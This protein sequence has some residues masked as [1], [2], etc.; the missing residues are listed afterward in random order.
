MTR[1]F[2]ELDL[3]VLNLLHLLL[4]NRRVGL[5]QPEAQRGLAEVLCGKDKQQRVCAQLHAVGLLH[6]AGVLVFQGGDVA[7]QGADLGVGAAHGAFQ[8]ADRGLVVPHQLFA[9]LDFLVEQA[10]LLRRVV[11]AALRLIQKV[12]CGFELLRDAVALFLKGGL[13]VGLGPSPSHDPHP[14]GQ[15]QGAGPDQGASVK[16]PCGV[17]SPREC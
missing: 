15:G 10:D 6:H 16:V 13:V 2:G 5:D 14:Q 7:L 12:F 3:G 4:P 8:R 1:T 11:A 9:K 17:Q